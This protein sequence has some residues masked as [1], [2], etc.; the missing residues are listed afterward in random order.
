MTAVYPIPKIVYPSSVL[1]PGST[2]TLQLTYQPRMIPLLTYESIRHTNVA[3]SG[4]TEQVWER[5][6][7]FLEASAEWIINHNSEAAGWQAFLASAAQGVP[8]DYYPD[9]TISPFTTYYLEDTNIKVEYVQLDIYR[10][11]FKMRKYVAW[12]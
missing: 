8:F 9:H 7:E 6:D 4:V 11:K 12:P 2:T 10:Y 3:S 1:S 5:T